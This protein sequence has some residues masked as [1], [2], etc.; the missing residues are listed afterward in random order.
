MFSPLVAYGCWFVLT[1]AIGL[2][3]ATE[4]DR[5]SDQNRHKMILVTGGA[6]YIG[7]HACVELLES[8]EQVVVFDNFSNSH[9]E[10]LQRVEKICGKPVIAVEGDIHD[11]EA[12]KKALAEHNCVAVIHFAGL[13][14]VKDSV[15]EPLDYYDNNVVGT[16]RLLRAMQRKRSSASS[17]VLRRPSTSFRNSFP[18]PKNIP[19]T[20]SITMVGRSSS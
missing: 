15:T 4:A 6:G 3:Y 16:C 2:P 8:G 1:Q 20:Q 18:I 9:R 19:S 13:K 7:S 11:Q 17:L 14:A 12:V 5:N 10:S